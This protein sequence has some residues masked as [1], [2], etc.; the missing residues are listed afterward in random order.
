MF[1]N[2]SWQRWFNLNLGHS[3]RGGSAWES[4]PPGMRST[5][6]TVLKTAEPTGTQAL[7]KL[8][9]RVT[10][11]WV[12]NQHYQIKL[13]FFCQ[14]V[15]GINPPIANQWREDENMTNSPINIIGISR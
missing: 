2:Q 15:N 5:P 1:V 7:P 9:Q 8:T 4:N 12:R 13:S 3:Q 14:E 11:L 10:I 6:Q